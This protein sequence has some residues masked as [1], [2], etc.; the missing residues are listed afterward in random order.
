MSRPSLV[1][2][3]AGNRAHKDPDKDRQ[4]KSAVG[5]G[6]LK[7][8]KFSKLVV[9]HK[10]KSIKRRRGRKQERRRMQFTKQESRRMQ[11]MKRSKQ[12][13]KRRIQARRRQRQ[14]IE[15]K[16]ERKKSVQARQRDKQE[17]KKK[18]RRILVMWIERRKG[19]RARKDEPAVL[20]RGKADS[21]KRQ[22]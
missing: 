10:H 2:V 9:Q 3:S 17:I 15:I 16:Q 19:G 18:R 14:K 8:Q 7:A 11:P 20:S 13:K 4:E 5:M 21:G 12:E 1:E 6:K 22:M